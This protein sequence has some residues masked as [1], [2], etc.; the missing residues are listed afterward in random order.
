[1]FLKEK[2]FEDKPGI[3]EKFLTPA[4]IELAIS[5]F[6][7]PALTNGATRPIRSRSR[8]FI[9]GF[10]VTSSLTFLLISIRVNPSMK[11]ALGIGKL[12]FSG[13][14]IVPFAKMPNVQLSMSNY[15]ATFFDL[16]V[17]QLG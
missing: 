11:V 5:E 3:K 6:D 12:S 14:C 16:A 4:R 15:Q 13:H 1:M 10:I 17:Y 8:A 7:L 9:G 2:E